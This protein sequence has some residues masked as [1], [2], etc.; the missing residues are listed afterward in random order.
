VLRASEGVDGRQTDRERGR[1]H[2]ERFCLQQTFLL[3]A[4]DAVQTKDRRSL[5]RYPTVALWKVPTHRACPGERG[6]SPTM[7]ADRDHGPIA[8]RRRHSKSCAA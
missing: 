7:S 5:S 1:P 4:I 6:S 3:H 2:V 8:G